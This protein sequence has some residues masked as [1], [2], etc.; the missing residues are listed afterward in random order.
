MIAL[1]NMSYKI[2]FPIAAIATLPNHRGR[3]LTTL[4]PGSVVRL[5]CKPNDIGL[6]RIQCRDCEYSVFLD[7]LKLYAS[8]LSIE[9]NQQPD[10]RNAPRMPG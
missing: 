9:P 3:F 7:D 1:Q 8:A 2:D 4:V 5:I 10:D 6:V